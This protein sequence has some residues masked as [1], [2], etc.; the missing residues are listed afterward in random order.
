MSFPAAGRRG[1][2]P[3]RCAF[4]PNS[5]Q[6][7][8]GYLVAG[9][10]GVVAR[11]VA[12]VAAGALGAVLALAGALPDSAP[13]PVQAATTHAAAASEVPRMIASQRWRTPAAAWSAPVIRAAAT[14]DPT[15]KLL[16]PACAK[17]HG[18]SWHDG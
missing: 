14:G 3:V 10:A 2:I 18:V 13:P 7:A 11:A 6:A 16:L 17:F 12:P 1:P 9:P 5:G 8:E 4:W 15:T